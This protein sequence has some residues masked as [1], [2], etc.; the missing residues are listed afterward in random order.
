MYEEVAHIG[1]SGLAAFL[2]NEAK[3]KSIMGAY[4]VKEFVSSHDR[5]CLSRR[6]FA[7]KGAMGIRFVG[8]GVSGGQQG[9][10]YGPSLMPGGNEKAWPFIKDI[11]QG[12]AAKSEDKCEACCEW[13][14]D[15]GAGHY[16]KMVHN[17]I[18]YGDMQLICEAY[19]I[20]KNALR[21]PRREI[22]DTFAKW[23][24]GMLNS[25][26]METTRDILYYNGDDGTPVIDKIMDQAGQKGTG[27]WTAINA[28]ALGMPVTLIAGAVLSR[29]LS[30]IKAERVEAS[31]K[32]KSAGRS[33]A[34]V[35][36]GNKMKFLDNLEQALYASEIVSCAQ[37]FMLM[38]KVH[39]KLQRVSRDCLACKLISASYRPQNSMVGS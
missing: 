28:I 23:N 34:F 5:N 32:L 36:E 9:A 13:I 15:D 33:H 18:E 35:L 12:I 27:K 22:G 31:A 3:C 37:G 30:S 6:S 14:G 16:V 1:L 10:R 39:Q 17:S 24:N 25:F 20:M 8:C 19:D 38:Q 29:C 4:S 2:A 26:L 11:F 7:D 21:M